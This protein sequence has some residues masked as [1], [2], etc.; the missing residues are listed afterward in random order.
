MIRLTAIHLLALG[1]VLSPRTVSAGSGCT[2]DLTNKFPAVV[3]IVVTPSGACTGFAVNPYQI[4]TAGHCLMRDGAAL[5]P[6][7]LKIHTSSNS[8]HLIGD[9]RDV[10]VHE[11]YEKYGKFDIAVIDLFEPVLT[12]SRIARDTLTPGDR[13]NI[14]GYGVQSISGYGPS[15]TTRNMG[16]NWVDRVDEYYLTLR[17]VIIPPAAQAVSDGSPCIIFFGDSGGGVGANDKMYAVQTI[18]TRI[19]AR[20]GTI[21]HQDRALRLD[22]P[23]IKEFLATYLDTSSWEPEVR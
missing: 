22:A 12:F 7:Q 14:G 5:S 6:H 3:R 2:A 4:V 17:S 16:E 21:I 1:V 13:V 19:W 15:S 23:G 20:D 11:K 10:H 8:G 18:G 9:A